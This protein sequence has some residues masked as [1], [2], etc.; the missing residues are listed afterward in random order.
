MNRLAV[1]L[2]PIVLLVL[3]A[4]VRGQSARDAVAQGTQAYDDLE[5][6]QAAGLLRRALAAQGSSALSREDAARALIYLTATELLRDRKD[7]ARAIARRLVITNPRYRPDELVFP[8]QLLLLYDVVRRVTPAVIGEAPADT[9]IRPGTDALTLRLYASAVHDIE[10]SLVALDGRV[11][12][13]LYRGPIGDSLSLPWNGLDSAGATLAAGS[14]AVRVSSFDRAGK[15]VRMLRMP[16][17]VLTAP[18]DTLPH[19]A[20]PADTVLRPEK[21]PFGPALRVLAPGV[22]A[23]LGTAFLPGLVAR[24]EQP[25]RGRLVIGGTLT[26]A[27]VTAFIARRPGRPIPENMT[28]NAALRAWRREDAEVARRNAERAKGTISVRIDAPVILTPSGS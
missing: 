15:V 13:T 8:P 20:A 27:S 23:G 24:G 19:P 3:P 6:E 10:A 11:M 9:T 7:S 25:S 12:R 5:F 1:W 18:A 16:L 21:Q 17:S 4:S 26:L 2:V 14:Y 22:L 28:H